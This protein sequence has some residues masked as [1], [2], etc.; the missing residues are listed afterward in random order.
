MNTTAQINP[1]ILDSV[2]QGSLVVQ[3][4]LLLLIALSILCW[5]VAWS[6][7]RYFKSVKAANEPFI[8]RFW[9]ATS[10]DSL[11]ENIDQYNASPVAQVFKAGYIE[12]QRLADSPL[13]KKQQS[14]QNDEFRLS[15]LDNMERALRKATDN[16]IQSMESKLTVLATTGSTGPFIGLFGTVWG[17]MDSFHKIGLTG[18]ASLAV[19]APGIS[20]A[21][22]TTA[23]GLVAAIPAVVLYNQ[24][25]S[26][27]KKQEV[28]L[29]NF[30]S[31]YLNIVKRNFFKGE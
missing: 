3:L 18:S 12:M 10:L 8:N 6:K 17:I 4:T 21:L 28:E 20:E 13:L 24:F 14:Q 19:V 23:I 11:Y 30:Q 2:L 26:Q 27:I 16:E 25:I 7:Y 5:A 15:G 22:F 9:K 31:D 29:N 1:S